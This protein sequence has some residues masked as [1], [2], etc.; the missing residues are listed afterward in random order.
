[1]LIRRRTLLSTIPVIAAAAGFDLAEI[2]AEYIPEFAT[3]KFPAE[4]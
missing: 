2:G 3:R 4:A 1:M